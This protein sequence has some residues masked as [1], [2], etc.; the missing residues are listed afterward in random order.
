[1]GE[2]AEGETLQYITRLRELCGCVGS[3][4][5]KQTKSAFLVSQSWEN[6]TNVFGPGTGNSVVVDMP[7]TYISC[8][9]G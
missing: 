1:M 5:A 9:V 3:G 8:D 7:V 2:Q 4:E 6:E